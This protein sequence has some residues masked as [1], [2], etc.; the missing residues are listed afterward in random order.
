MWT[1]HD[2]QQI[3]NNQHNQLVDFNTEHRTKNMNVSWRRSRQ[4]HTIRRHF[5]EESFS[6]KTLEYSSKK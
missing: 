4:S 6:S 5:D 3:S 2:G 1:N